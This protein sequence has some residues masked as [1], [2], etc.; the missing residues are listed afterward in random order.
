M[1]GVTARGYAEQMSFLRLSEGYAPNRA[2]SGNPGPTNSNAH[3]IKRS[4]SSV[5][6]GAGSIR[7]RETTLAYT[8][9]LSAKYRALQK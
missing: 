7:A 9:L 2:L 5:F 8:L 6:R 3:T 4:D 1:S